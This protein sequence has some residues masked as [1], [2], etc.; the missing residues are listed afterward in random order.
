MKNYLIRF[1]IGVAAFFLLAAPTMNF[2]VMLP[3]RINFPPHI[4][5]VAMI[6][7]SVPEDNVRNAIEGGLTGEF[8]GQDKHAT[9]I[10]MDGIHSIMDNS[11]T[12]AF[13]RT[14]ESLPGGTLIGAAFP[15][16]IAQLRRAF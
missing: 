5:S 1:T 15:D 10:V 16:P 8:I 11:P 6:D 13:K 14:T 3:A 9:Q 12:L 4:K 2:D 7:R